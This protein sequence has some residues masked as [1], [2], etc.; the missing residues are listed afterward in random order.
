MSN[1]LSLATA[2]NQRRRD[3]GLSCAIVATRA[4]LGLRTVQRVLSG[5]EADAG[6]RT[7]CLIADVLG[8]SVTLAMEDLNDVRRRQAERKSEKLISIV[9]GTSALETQTL[10]HENAVALKE[11]LVRDLLAGS[12][13]K[14]WAE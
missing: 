11:R 10:D 1:P 4:G 14:L 8:A 6:L 2:L 9:Q 5:K 3:L 13:R 7:L 12:A